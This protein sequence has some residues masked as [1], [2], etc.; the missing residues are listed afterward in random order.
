MTSRLHKSLKNARVA[1]FFYF[2]ALVLAFISRKVFIDTLGTELVGLS[3]TMRNIL[4]FLNLAE[5]GVYTAVATSLYSPLVKDEKVKI[6]EIISLFGFFYRIIGLFILAAGVILSIFL[7][8]IFS[9]TELS[10]LILYAAYFTFLATTLVSYF[11]NYKQVLLVADQRQ[12]MLTRITNWL[13]I[14]KITLQILYVKYIAPDYLVWLGIELS[15]GLIIRFMLN[16]KAVKEYPWLT[17]NLGEGR[18]LFVKYK[19]IILKVK[20]L[21][22][23]KIAE[24]ALYQTGNILVFALTSLSMVTY[25]TNYTIIFTKITTL[26]SS[27]LGSNLAG[28]GHVIAEKDAGKIKKVFWEFNA[29]FYWI[30]GSLVFSL[31]YLT[32][33]FITLWLGAEFILEKAVFIIMLFNV[34]VRITRQTINFFINGYGIFRDV[35]APWTEAAINIGIAIGVGYFYGLLGVVLGM[36]ISSMLIVVLWKPFFLYREGFKEK[37]WPFWKYTGIYIFLLIACWALFYPWIH[38]GWLPEPDTYLK[39]LFL[40]LCL[41]IPFTILYAVMLYFSAPGM[42]DF[43]HRLRPIFI[44]KLENFR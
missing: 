21:F 19:D 37:F 44:S 14:L 18:A 29:M 13:N 2:M 33:P 17:T 28:V 39:W 41:S 7:P 1:F 38:S 22:V 34:Y 32:E 10:L 40:A 8:Q 26:V 20:Q 43:Y 24:F 36:A 15:F 25:Y 23:H 30:A 16:R 9:R 4:G 42:K 11:N 6:N 27:T 3:A 31:Y 35:W 12:Y 5:L